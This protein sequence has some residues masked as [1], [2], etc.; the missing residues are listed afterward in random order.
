MNGH[1][2]TPAHA[3]LAW[4]CIQADHVVAV[5]RLA[6]PCDQAIRPAPMTVAF[7]VCETEMHCAELSGQPGQQFIRPVSTALPVNRLYRE[8]TC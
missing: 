6:N 4:A 5:D 7:I 8:V 3:D 1:V 2:A